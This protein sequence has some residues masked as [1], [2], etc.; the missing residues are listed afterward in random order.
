MP[1]YRI[2]VAYT[3]ERASDLALR[4]QNRLLAVQDVAERLGGK[5]IGGWIEFGDY[6]VMIILEMLNFVDIAAITMAFYAGGAVRAINVTP[7]LTIEEMFNANKR[8]SETGYKPPK[9]QKKKK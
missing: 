1:T 8:V 5:V 6:N 9:L 7:L 4:P 3:P 2:E